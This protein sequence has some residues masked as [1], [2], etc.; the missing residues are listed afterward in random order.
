MSKAPCP[1][2][3]QQHLLRIDHKPKP[4]LSINRPMFNHY[5]IKATA[6]HSYS[7]ALNECMHADIAIYIY[8]YIYIYIRVHSYSDLQFLE[9][10]VA[11]SLWVFLCQYSEFLMKHSLLPNGIPYSCMHVIANGIKR[12][13]TFHDAQ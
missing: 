13:N 5:K 3:Q 4:D 11:L 9:E 1:R 2:K 8:I 6:S 12:H 7:Y 10:S